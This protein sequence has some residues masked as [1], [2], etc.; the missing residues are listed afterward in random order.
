MLHSNVTNRTFKRAL[1]GCREVR[2]PVYFSGLDLLT[3]LT[4]DLDHGLFNVD[5][6]AVMAGAQVVYA[7]EGSLYVGSQRYVAGLDTPAE[8]PASTVTEIHRFDTTKAGETS[9]RSSGKVPGFVLNQYALGEHKGDLRVASTEDPL[10]M[11]GAQQRESE[12]SVTV[13]RERDGRL[14]Q[15][16]KVGG[17]GKGERIYAVR[18]L[19]DVGYLVTFRQVDPLYT[20][21]LSNP[22]APKVAGELK[23]TGYSAYLHPIGEDL[24]LGVGQ[25]ATEQGR[26]HRIT[27]LGLRR[28]RPGQPQAPAPETAGRRRLILTGGVRSARLPLVGPDADRSAAA[29]GILPGQAVLGSRRRAR[30]QGRGD[31][32]DR[33]H[34]AP[35]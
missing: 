32:G 6:D 25:D 4:I 28:L 35:G 12:S 5:R 7:S 24:L 1:V 13:L 20:L 3:V 21:D 11:G 26:A 17:L 10:W 19:G 33:A 22:A 23:I 9:Y 15:I 29:A 14:E 34:R 18:F 16:G 31:R 27:G 30:A 2:H 8:I